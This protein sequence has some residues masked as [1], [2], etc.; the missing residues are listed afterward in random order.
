MSESARPPDAHVLVGLLGDEPTTG[1]D[2]V[3][4][5]L[6]VSPELAERCLAALERDGLVERVSD[7]E[8]RTAALDAGELRELYPAVAILERLALRLSPRFGAGAL[9]ELR[10]VNARLRGATDAP[11][12]IAADYDFHQVLTRECGNPELLEVLASIKRALVPYER[13]YMIDAARVERSAAQHDGIIA[14]L[15]ADDRDRAAE[16][17]HQNFVSTLPDV[18]SQFEKSD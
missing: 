5:R 13:A 15:E 2:A 12:A 17:V 6:C 7:A 10:A 4:A 9:D 3:A 1:T 14:A 18:A 11:A 16:L 8:W